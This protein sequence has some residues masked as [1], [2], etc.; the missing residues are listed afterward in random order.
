MCTIERLFC[1]L[2]D[3]KWIA[4]LFG[5]HSISA[6]VNFHWIF[7]EVFI[8]FYFF[9]CLMAF[10]AMQSSWR[11]CRFNFDFLD[12]IVFV[13]Q[14]LFSQTNHTVTNVKHIV[15]Y[16]LF[17]WF[18]FILCML[19]FSLTFQMSPIDFWLLLTI[20]TWLTHDYVWFFSSLS[21]SFAKQVS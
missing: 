14:I 3:F 2:F 12:T 11:D 7:A 13:Q 5:I 9:C 17:E 8:F 10:C 19:S 20:F 16:D 4:I 18:H 15:R 1:I 21:L 6:V